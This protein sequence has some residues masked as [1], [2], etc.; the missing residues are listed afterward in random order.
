M[1]LTVEPGAKNGGY[2]LINFNMWGKS[3]ILRDITMTIGS[4]GDLTEILL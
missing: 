1:F 3:D 4:I 2:H